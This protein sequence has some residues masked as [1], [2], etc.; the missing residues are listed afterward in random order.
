MDGRSG[1]GILC[2]I[3]GLVAVW[4]L[5]TGRA[6]ALIARLVAAPG[7]TASAASTSSRATTPSSSGTVPSGNSFSAVN[8]ALVNGAASTSFAIPLGTPSVAYGVPV[9]GNAT[10]EPLG[11]ATIA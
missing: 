5:V 4:L 9:G 11:S 2:V 8:G 6:N 3:A 1:F 10:L 7:A